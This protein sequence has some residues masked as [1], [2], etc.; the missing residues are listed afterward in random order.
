MDYSENLSSIPKYEPQDAH[1]NSRQLSLHC[2]VVQAVIDEQIKYAYHI[3][4][5]KKKDY[6][7]T[8]TVINDL[9]VTFDDYKK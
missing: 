6:L 8:A 5:D 2:T 9:L 7:F 3:S 1:F 4:E